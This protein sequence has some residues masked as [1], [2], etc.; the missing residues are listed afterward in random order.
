VPAG[1]AVGTL[2]H[3]LF[4]DGA[5]QA[6]RQIEVQVG[7]T[8]APAAAPAVAPAP[9]PGACAARSRFAGLTSADIKALKLDGC[10][11]DAAVDAAIKACNA[12]ATDA[13]LKTETDVAKVITAL[14]EKPNA[15]KTR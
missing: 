8:A 12:S 9:A 1:S 14:G 3:L 15:C 4:A 13:A 7:A 5:G 6:E 10:V 11:D 2:I